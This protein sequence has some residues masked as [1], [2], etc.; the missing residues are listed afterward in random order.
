MLIINVG[1]EMWQK[2]KNEKL[3]LIKIVECSNANE[4]ENGRTEGSSWSKWK[5]IMRFSLLCKSL[6]S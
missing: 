1:E 4:T 5:L 6:A 2:S 3:K